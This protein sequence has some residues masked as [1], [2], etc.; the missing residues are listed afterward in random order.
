MSKQI[1]QIYALVLLRRQDILI[2]CPMA[3][4]R[5]IR[6][7]LLWVF[8]SYMKNAF[9][10]IYLI[11]LYFKVCL[12]VCKHSSG[13]HPTHHIL[14]FLPFIFSYQNTEFKDLG[15]TCSRACLCSSLNL[16]L[17]LTGRQHNLISWVFQ[18]PRVELGTQAVRTDAGVCSCF[19][20]GFVWLFFSL[21]S[22]LKSAKNFRDFTY[23][24]LAS[25]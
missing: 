9:L 19:F 4:G 8:K 13:N 5:F 21:L 15:T 12:T 20:W 22:L 23:C 24:L 25:I 16:A 7:L 3:S 11:F 14:H 6:V 10:N 18:N 1:S 2:L 17:F